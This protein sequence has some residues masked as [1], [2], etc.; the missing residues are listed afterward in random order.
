VAKLLENKELSGLVTALGC[1]GC[2]EE[3]AGRELEVRSRDGDTR[4]RCP[5]ALETAE[6][7]QKADERAMG[8]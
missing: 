2:P 4:V 6:Q 1:A 3:A 7:A 8:S 5:Q